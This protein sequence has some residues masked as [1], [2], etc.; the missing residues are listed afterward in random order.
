MENL[1]VNSEYHRDR[2]ISDPYEVVFTSSNLRIGSHRRLRFTNMVVRDGVR[3]YFSITNRLT[4]N[5]TNRRI[6]SERIERDSLVT[7][8]GMNRK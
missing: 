1:R 7:A 8:F 3:V 2:P 4:T 5:S 6:M